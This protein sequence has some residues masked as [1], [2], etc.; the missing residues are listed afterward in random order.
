MRH[1]NQDISPGTF[2]TKCLQ[3]ASDSEKDLPAKKRIASDSEKELP[4]VL[5]LE[6]LHAS[7]SKKYDRKLLPEEFKGKITWSDS[8]TT[9][10]ELTVLAWG[11]HHLVYVSPNAT[12][13]VK[14]QPLG[15]SQPAGFCL[16]EVKEKKDHNKE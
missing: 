13:V 11:A 14:A 8:T 9:V 15:T 4:V 12:W 10:H 5:K 1:E 3:L 6:I 16:Q 2:D 7:P